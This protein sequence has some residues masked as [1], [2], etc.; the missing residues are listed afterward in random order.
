MK[1]CMIILPILLLLGL[2]SF[3]QLKTESIFVYF[4]TNKSELGKIGKQQLDSICTIFID[5]KIT[6]IDIYGHTDYRGPDKL[7]KVLSDKRVNAVLKYIVSKGIDVKYIEKKKGFGKKEP[8]YDNKTVI[9]RRLNRRVEIVYKYEDKGLKKEVNELSVE[10]VTVPPRA[11]DTVIV[12]PKGTVIF[13]KDCA[14]TPIDYKDVKWEFN[15]FFDQKSIQAAG[16]RTVTN[17]G[18]CLVSGGMAFIKATYKGKEIQPKCP[19]E[20]AFP[21][22][23]LN[24]EMQLFNSDTNT[25][26]EKTTWILNNTPLEFDST[27]ITARKM[28]IKY[29]PSKMYYRFS[30]PRLGG[31]NC[32]VIKGVFGLVGRHLFKY[33]SMTFKV[34]KSADNNI[35]IN[36]EEGMHNIQS[37]RIA[38]NKFYFPPRCLDI[39]KVTAT[40]TKNG[41]KM[42]CTKELNDIKYKKWRRMYKFKKKWF[43]PAK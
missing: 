13:M 42:T 6:D 19:I 34:P 36:I 4:K 25:T 31:L 24:P 2:K 32:D 10:V 5:L 37:Q 38:S 27:G 17:D 3:A 16:I 29:T 22:A 7:N 28:P 30:T 18:R 9:G 41:V 1:K 35:V 26:P 15:E 20:I 40:Y 11:K 39:D 21:T 14:F 12:G 33:K 8:K 23:S 43:V